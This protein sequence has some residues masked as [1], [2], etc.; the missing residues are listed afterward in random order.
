[1]NPQITRLDA[2]KYEE[3]IICFKITPKLGVQTYT[4]VKCS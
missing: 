3:E 4:K 1:M 2:Y